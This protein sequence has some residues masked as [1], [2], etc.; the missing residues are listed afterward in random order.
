MY[1]GGGFWEIS[2]YTDFDPQLNIGAEDT[3]FISKHSFN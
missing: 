3:V 1:G 2:E